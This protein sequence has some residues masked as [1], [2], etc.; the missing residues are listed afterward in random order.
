MSYERIGSIIFTRDCEQD[1]TNYA[2]VY[3]V[4]RGRNEFRVPLL[5]L[6]KSNSQY[7]LKYLLNLPQNER[8]TIHKENG[9]YFYLDVTKVY[10]NTKYA[11]CRQLL[12]YHI[13]E[14]KILVLG[15]GIGPYSIYLA[16]NN[17]FIIGYDFNSICLQFA[18]INKRINKV[19]NYFPLTGNIIHLP[20]LEVDVIV[21]IIPT[22]ILNYLLRLTYLSY[23]FHYSVILVNNIKILVHLLTLLSFFIVTYKF[24]K[25]YC[26][27]VG[28][29]LLILENKC[30]KKLPF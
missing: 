20:S 8:L 18:K 6:C 5:E 25:S 9:K 23:K 19:F 12:T 13:K 16:S 26:K 24:I 29:Y 1:F 3:K 10:Y 7:K 17:S 22:L 2:A 15:D 28:I 11:T 4:N 27:G 21:S 30:Y 14:S